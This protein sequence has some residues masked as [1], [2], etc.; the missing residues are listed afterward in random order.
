M[1][2]PDINGF[3]HIDL[4]VTDA[5]RSAKWW[6]EVMGFTPVSV[7]ERQGHVARGMYHPCGVSVILVQ[8]D[9]RSGGRFDER[10]VGLGPFRAQSS[11]PGRA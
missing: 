4:T 2:A 10:T 1:T 5:K 9:N 8:H 11:Q 3:G 6:E 7:S